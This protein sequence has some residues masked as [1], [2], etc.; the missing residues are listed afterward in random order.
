MSDVRRFKRP[1][2][3]HDDRGVTLIEVIVASVLSLTV[4]IMGYQILNAT[5]STAQ[6]VTY[7]ASNATNA[8]IALDELEANLR[9]A[10]GFWIVNSTNTQVLGSSSSTSVSGQYLVVSNSTTTTFG[11]QPA[12]AEWAVT[13]SGL[14]E[15]TDP[16]G[17][18]S[19]G[20]PS[21]MMAGVSLITFTAQIPH[22]L[23]I[24]LT[25]NQQS[26]S[27]ANAVAVHDLISPDNLTTSQA[28]TSECS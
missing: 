24:D 6:A 17:G 28:A 13:T 15:A 19:L 8:R 18:G 5:T 12:C 7:Q 9:Y 1:T 22:L 23:E 20:T 16:T 11:G 26:R 2:S 4:L 3:P 10:N 14:T 27:T 25:E 21:L